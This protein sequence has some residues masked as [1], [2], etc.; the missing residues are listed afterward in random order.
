MKKHNRILNFFMHGAA[1]LILPAFAAIAL[2]SCDDDNDGANGLVVDYNVDIKPCYA[3]D[4]GRLVEITETKTWTD[5]DF[6]QAVSQAIDEI[7]DHADLDD[8]KLAVGAYMTLKSPVLSALFMLEKSGGWHYEQTNFTY[9]SV[10]STGDS[11]TFS[12]GV[13]YPM[14][15][16]CNH[17]MLAGISLYHHFLTTSQESRPTNITLPVLLRTLFNEAVIFSDTQGFGATANL[18]TPFLDGYSKGRQAVDAMVAALQ[19]LESKSFKLSKKAYYEN[20]GASLGALQALGALRYLESDDCPDW[21]PDIVPG[22]G[23]YASTGPIEPLSVFN[24]YLEVN[25]LLAFPEV[26]L[27]M[28]MTLMASYPDLARGYEPDD[29]FNPEISKFSKVIDGKKC[30]LFQAIQA[31][32]VS[33]TELRSFISQQ[34]GS[35]LKRMLAPDMLDGNGNFNPASPK[36]A[37]IIGALERMSAIQ[38]WTPAHTILLSHSKDDE[39]MLYDQAYSSYEKLAAAAPDRVYFTYSYGNHRASTA[40]AISRIIC[41]QH[42]SNRSALADPVVQALSDLLMQCFSGL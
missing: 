41:M 25:D 17:H 27:C 22:I 31:S 10:T 2:S 23:T 8:I 18:D 6:R 37:I 5:D 9:R 7:S 42:P 24:S 36:G 35:S 16:S 15:D 11:A 14:A 3:G 34:F 12:G 40:M 29:F 1:K 39:V 30:T 20:Y 4:G 21:I 38:D 13:A 19:V 26:P 33:Q 28:V 32:A